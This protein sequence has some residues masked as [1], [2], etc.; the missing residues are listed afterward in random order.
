MKSSKQLVLF[1]ISLLAKSVSLGRPPNIVLILADDLDSDLGGMDP[2]AKTRAWLG[3]QGVTLNQSFVSTPV[4]CPSRAS[5]L[6]GRYQHN[7]HVRNNSITGNCS[8]EAWQRG[9]ETQTFATSLQDAGYVT[10]YA[11]KYLNAYGHAAAGGVA[12]VPPGW[13]FW[14]GL[15]GNSKYYD[16]TLSI[17]GKKER[18]GSDY[19]D[20]YL[21]DVIGR[22]AASFLDMYNSRSIRNPFLMV[23][24]PPSPHA[25]F[26][27]APQYKNY[28]SNRTAPR[29]PA[30]NRAKA[31]DKPKHWFVNTKPR[32]LNETLTDK[33][34]EVFRYARRPFFRW[35]IF[36]SFNHN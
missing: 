28:F 30:F 3:Q 32:P 27:P 18:H 19:G 13:D 23:L 16:Y 9:S 8:S 34:D 1:S 10:F 20:D 25:P 7:T 12:H 26:T 6:T 21:T 36:P 24:S 31:S 29:T 35:H 2:L 14:A 33:I 4:C 5:L 22:K 17:N 11:G 15:V